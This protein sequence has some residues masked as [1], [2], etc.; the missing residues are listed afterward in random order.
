MAIKAKIFS[1]DDCSFCSQAKEFLNGMEVEYEEVYQPT[2][3]VPQIYAGD[4]HIGGYTEL[5][6]LSQSLSKWDETFGA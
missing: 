3:R 5:I 1:R 4:I 2:G 6:E